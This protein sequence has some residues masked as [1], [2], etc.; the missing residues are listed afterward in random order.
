DRRG[1]THGTLWKVA[2]DGTVLATTDLGTLSGASSSYV[3]KVSARIGGVVQAAGFSHT[4]S[5][6]KKGTLWT[7]R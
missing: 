6:I 4:S 7:V 5:G 2:A 1:A 3:S